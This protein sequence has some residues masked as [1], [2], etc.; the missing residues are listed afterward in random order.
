MEDPRCVFLVECR[1]GR[2][3]RVSD[4]K[5]ACNCMHADDFIDDFVSKETMGG[6][7]RHLTSCVEAEA[8]RLVGLGRFAA[9]E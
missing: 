8:P 9:M 7:R 6:Q 1:R 3:V 2:G 5:C 4:G